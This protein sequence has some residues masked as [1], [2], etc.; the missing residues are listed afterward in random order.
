MCS[1]IHWFMDSLIHWFIDSLSQWFMG[2]FSKVESAIFCCATSMCP[3]LV[4]F[5]WVPLFCVTSRPFVSLLCPR[6]CMWPL[7]TPR[8][9]LLT[10]LC[11]SQGYELLNPKLNGTWRQ[12]INCLVCD[13]LPEATVFLPLG[14]AETTWVRLYWQRSDLIY[15]YTHMYDELYKVVLYG[16]YWRQVQ[17]LSMWVWG[18]SY[19]YQIFEPRKLSAAN[20]HMHSMSNFLFSVQSG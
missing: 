12:T 9:F 2:A 19:L 10:P 17:V 13:L 7:S 11:V 16:F 3:P 18:Y 4:V 20:Q 1:M 14:N 15:I 5:V 8:E 6:P